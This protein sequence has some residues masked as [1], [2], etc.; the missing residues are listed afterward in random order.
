MN[1]EIRRILAEIRSDNEGR[2]VGKMAALSAVRALWLC[3]QVEALAR[4]V[5]RID[6]LRIAAEEIDRIN[7]AA[8]VAE[9]EALAAENERLRAEFRTMVGRLVITCPECDYV[10]LA[11]EA[12]GD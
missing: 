3:D 8:W 11:R 4:E 6:G 5:E 2:A 7:K 12:S 1:D 9:R 10:G